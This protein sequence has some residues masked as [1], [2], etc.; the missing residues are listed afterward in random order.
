MVMG[1]GFDS[2]KFCPCAK[3][4]PRRGREMHAAGGGMGLRSKKRGSFKLAELSVPVYL[5]G[6]WTHSIRKELLTSYLATAK[7]I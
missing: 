1:C 5:F 6:L 2:F 4:W 7:K 3:L